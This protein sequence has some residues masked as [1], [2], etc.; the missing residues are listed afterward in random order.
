MSDGT[1]PY[2]H[3]PELRGRI[4]P[5]DESRYR[6]IDLDE[7]DQ[8]LRGR[9]SP[10]P[11]RVPNDEREA[12]R[13]AALRGRRDRDLW[14]FACGSLM[15][16]PALRFAEV[17][18]A[19]LGGYER[20]FCLETSF[21]RGTEE[22]PGLMLGLVPGQGCE[23]LAFRVPA[24]R[25]EVES[26]ILWRREMLFYGYA[27]TFEPIDTVHGTEEAVVFAADPDSE[28]YAGDLTFEEQA[29][30][31]AH[32]AGFLGSAFEYLDNVLQ[33]L[34]AVGIEDTGIAALHARA[35]D[36]RESASSA[37]SASG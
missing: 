5:Y 29:R 4:V 25:I 24:E 14:V 20:R 8:Q 17:R 33:Q 21:G 22:L 9:G 19:R 16:D 3:H 12:A 27:P 2:R 26:E 23:G 35:C 30:C 34:R 13:R 28:H 1:D 31:M 18:R 32:A 36:L 7:L 37:G 11:R 6:D 15:W 10:G